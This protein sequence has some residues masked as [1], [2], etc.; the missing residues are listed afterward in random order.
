M[1]PE[2]QP[3]GN[4]SAS[5]QYKRHN[6]F[7][8]LFFLLYRQKQ[9]IYPFPVLQPFLP[10]LPDAKKLP[11]FSASRLYYPILQDI[12]PVNKEPHNSFLT[13]WLF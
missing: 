10:N 12:H 11:N 7:P 6:A 13:A 2:S 9:I 3:D 8:E 5:C 1:F 4:T